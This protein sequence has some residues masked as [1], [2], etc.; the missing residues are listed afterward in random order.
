M[1][2]LEYFLAQFHK[3]TDLEAPAEADRTP[4][5]PPSEAPLRPCDFNSD[6]PAY[7][8]VWLPGNRTR[9]SRWEACPLCKQEWAEQFRRD[10][11]LVNLLPGEPVW[12][13]QAFRRR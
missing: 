1:S 4:F 13:K 5:R 7:A 8:A 3:A 2:D 10:Q 11:R 6:H 12:S 9:A